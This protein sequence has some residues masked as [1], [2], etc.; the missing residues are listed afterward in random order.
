MQYKLMGSKGD[1]LH[2]I[3]ESLDRKRSFHIDDK[4]KF[5]LANDTVGK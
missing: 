2:S 4:H 1:L 3:Y 5:G